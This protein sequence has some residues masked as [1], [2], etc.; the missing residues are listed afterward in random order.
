L[1]QINIGREL[2]RAGTI[3]LLVFIPHALPLPFYTYVVVGLLLVMIFLKTDEKNI[4]DF[5]IT[6]QGFDF[7]VV[8]KAIGWAVVWTAFN[9][10]I[11]IPFIFAFFDVPEYTEYNFIRSSISTLLFIIVAAWMVGGLYEEIIFRG[12]ILRSFE[13]WTRSFWAATLVSSVLFGLYHWQQGLFGIIPSCLGG[14]FWSWILKRYKGNLWY[15]VVSH[16]V[17]D[18]IALIMLYFGIFGYFRNFV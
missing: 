8:C 13:Q 10:L 17:Y 5:G 15:S 7:K 1:K 14:F 12:F 9:Q 2:L 4:G 6:K 11:Y 16:A 18:T 3:I